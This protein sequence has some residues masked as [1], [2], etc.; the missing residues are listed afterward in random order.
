[1]VCSVKYRARSLISDETGRNSRR[2]TADTSWSLETQS[3]VLHLSFRN[4]EGMPENLSVNFSSHLFHHVSDSFY[5]LVPK[6][7]AS[8]SERQFC[9]SNPTHLGVVSTRRC[10]FPK[11][12]PVFFALVLGS[13][14]NSSLLCHT[15]STC[16]TEQVRRS[17]GCWR[18]HLA[19][20]LQSVKLW[21]ME[22]DIIH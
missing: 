4:S 8:C 7:T 12:N 11:T 2:V 22:S 13:S 1:M 16:L 18:T 3:P 15:C 19:S 6:I 20:I 9:V 21:S 17:P 5:T 14:K 10:W